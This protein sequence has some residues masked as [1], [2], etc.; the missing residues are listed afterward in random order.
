MSLV[1][2]TP[3]QSLDGFFDTDRFYG[4]PRV[5]EQQQEVLPK[6]N[7]IEKDEAFHL[8]AEVPGVTEKDVSV[9]FHDGILTLKSQLEKSS[10]YQYDKNNYRICEFGKQNFS[11]SFRLSDQIDSEKVVASIDQG[12]LNITL[13]KKEQAKPKK[14]DVKV[15]T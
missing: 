3:E 7:V 14:I 15:A 1:T 13:P 6:V 12:I 5:H 10:Q 2:F 9:E 11:R 8:E 4:F